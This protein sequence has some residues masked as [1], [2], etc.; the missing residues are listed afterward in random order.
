[1]IEYSS[2]RQF[3]GNFFPLQRQRKCE[4]GQSICLNGWR[5]LIRRLNSW[6]IPSGAACTKENARLWH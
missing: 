3:V 4:I 5:K 2:L 1:M 6:L